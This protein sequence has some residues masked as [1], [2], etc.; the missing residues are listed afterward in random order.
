VGARLPALVM[1][2]VVP[3]LPANATT[4]TDSGLTSNTEYSY[5]V[6]A[7]STVGQALP[8]LEEASCA[9]TDAS[10]RSEHAGPD[11]TKLLRR[12]SLPDSGST[13]RPA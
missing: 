10:G 12:R 2:E 3:A 1:P 9:A 5:R 7:I 11:V 6:F 4:A 8:P 13:I